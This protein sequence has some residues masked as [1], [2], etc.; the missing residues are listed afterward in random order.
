MADIN[1]LAKKLLI[2]QATRKLNGNKEDLAE[3]IHTAKE[4][5]KN[6]EGASRFMDGMDESLKKNTPFSG[7]LLR[8]GK[9]LSKNA[10]KKLLENLI[11]NWAIEGQKK[12]RKIMES[13]KFCPS[14]G[15]ISPWMKCNLNCTGCY[16]GMY[17]KQGE[18]SEADLE[19]ILDQFRE[20]G[21]YFA[22]ISGGEPYIKRDLL[23][24]IFKK[25]NDMYFLTYT[26][27]TFL[28]EATCKELAKLGNVTP[29]ISV[30]GWKAETDARRGEGMWEKIHQS[31]ANLRKAG[32]LFGTSLTATRHNVDVITD[33]AFVEHFMNEGALYSWYFMFMPV[34][35]DPIL[36]LVPTPEQRVLNGNRVAALR[37]RYPMF[38]ADFWNDGPAVNGCLAGGRQ[39]F[40]ILNDGRVEAC[41]FA[42]FGVDNIHDKP[43]IDIV[44]SDFFRDI[45]AQFPYNESA[46]LRRPCMI[47]DNPE[48]LRNVVRKYVLPESHKHSEDIVNDPK[49]IAFV[50][51]YAKRLYELQEPVWQKE[52]SDPNNYWYKEGAP[53]KALFEARTAGV[54][55]ES[56]GQKQTPPQQTPSPKGTQEEKKP[57]KEKVTVS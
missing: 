33:E 57:E 44:N 49:V 10:K 18:L 7:I 27:G 4:Y 19:N 47:I 52:I 9:S 56:V 51:D 42:H 20:N 17:L 32:V 28:D 12:R 55:I 50:D 16:S 23:L 40:H 30:E 26:N 36:D 13:G 38:L 1:P 21:M 46:N 45:R 25:Y 29:A 3:I 11:F 31:M 6:I 2:A 41:V 54:L 14:F 15:V 34:G 48:V 5:A 22:V 24:R 43:I 8:A 39:Y 53:Y 37:D 35:K